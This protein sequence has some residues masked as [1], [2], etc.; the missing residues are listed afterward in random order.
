MDNKPD[1]NQNNEPD[2]DEDKKKRSPWILI[3]MLLLVVAL[4]FVLF[5]IFSGD[6]EESGVKAQAVKG[7]RHHGWT[8]FYFAK[9]GTWKMLDAA[10][11]VLKEQKYVSSDRERDE[12]LVRKVDSGGILRIIKAAGRWKQVEVLENGNVVATGWIDA[13]ATRKVEKVEK[14]K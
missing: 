5:N 12:Y 14:I 4:A 9:D 7:E 6:G 1:F 2:N 8:P 10:S 11:Y 3:L 13:D